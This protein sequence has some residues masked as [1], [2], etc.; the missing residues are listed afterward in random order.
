MDIHVVDN[1]PPSDIARTLTVEPLGRR[2]HGLGNFTLDFSEVT[3]LWCCLLAAH[4]N[5]MTKWVLNV[6][7]IR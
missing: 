2:S 7:G 4:E 6:H 3:N 1:V 5:L